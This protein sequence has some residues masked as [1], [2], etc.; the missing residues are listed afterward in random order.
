MNKLKALNV[1]TEG[2]TREEALAVI[3]SIMTEK[4][5]T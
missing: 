2:L 1:S 5:Y 4:G 3:S